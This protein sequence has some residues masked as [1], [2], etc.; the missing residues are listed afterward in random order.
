MLKHALQAPGYTKIFY[1]RYK[2][3]KGSFQGWLGSSGASLCRSAISWTPTDWQLQLS[4][5]GK[6]AGCCCCVQKNST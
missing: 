1:G 2:D 5:V 6:A 4:L 3:L